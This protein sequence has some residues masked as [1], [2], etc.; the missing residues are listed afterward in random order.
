MQLVR[1]CGFRLLSIA[2]HRA[3][4][5][6]VAPFF[7][8]RLGLRCAACQ[9]LWVSPVSIA[10]SAL[11]CLFLWRR[12][13]LHHC[14]QRLALPLSAAGA[15]QGL[16]VSVLCLGTWTPVHLCAASLAV[17]P[18]YSARTGC[19]SLGLR[20]APA[21]SCTSHSVCPTA[22]PP[23]LSVA[24]FLRAPQSVCRCVAHLYALLV[25]SGSARQS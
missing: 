22:C 8:S 24:P 11:Y 14:A 18:R 4:R 16:A 12:L 25:S 5:E 2:S 21:P 3:S 1:R 10:L 7:E 23:Q 15:P 17:R 13:C 9:A 6:P 19:R 20:R